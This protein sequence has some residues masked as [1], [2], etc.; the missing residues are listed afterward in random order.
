MYSV[1][2]KSQNLYCKNISVTFSRLEIYEK[3]YAIIQDCR[4]ENHLFNL[5][6]YKAFVP[7]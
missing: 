7:F 3:I 2:L 1:I 5:G 4:Q 6:L